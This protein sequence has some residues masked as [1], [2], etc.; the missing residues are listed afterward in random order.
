MR[1]EVDDVRL[2]FDVEGCGLTVEGSAM[3][4]RPTVVLLHGGPGADHSLFKPEF[5]AVAD[6]AQV[7]YLDQRGSGRSDRSGPAKW[8]WERWADDVA[9]FCRAVGVGSCVL[10]GSSSG[11]MVGMLCAARHSELVA[12]LVL[13]STFGVPARLEESLEVFERR[14]GPMA[15]EAARRYLGGDTSPAAA[16]AWREYGLPLYGSANDG[17]M[18][19]RRDRARING[20]VQAHF[21][22]GGCGPADVAEWAGGVTCPTLILAG[23]D[24]PVSP[25]AAA[26][27]LAASLRNSA[28]QVETLAGV[29]HGVFRQA[30]QPALGFLRGFLRQVAP[31]D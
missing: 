31:S 6:V 10:V 27:R 3:V 5:S 29:G 14:G 21:R 25:V 13:D 19:T 8:T 12:G 28:V 18:A 22:R 9:G 7:I 17:D 11:G 4:I 24:D 15:R 26:R 23:E 16:E 20:E 2:F 1:V 30:P